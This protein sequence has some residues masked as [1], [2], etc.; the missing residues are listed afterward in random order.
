[1]LRSSIPTLA[2]FL[3]AVGCGNEAP[4]PTSD[5]ARASSQAKSAAPTA[6]AAPSAA[7]APS[8]TATADAPAPSSASAA[9]SSS[10]APSAPLFP[11][12]KPAPGAPS[13]A[14]FAAAPEI[15]VK[16]SSEQKCSTKVLQGWFEMVCGEAEGLVRARKVD[17]E[18]GF[19][20]ASVVFEPDVEGG[21]TMRFVA[22][23]PTSGELSR[24][25]FWG[26]DLHEIF[27]TLENT[28]KGW[29]GQLTGKRP[30]P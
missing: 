25:R 11:S 10:A 15:A 14:D 16:A 22:A 19:E 5:S 21:K 7:P 20:K 23:L 24:A 30:S 3:F 4:A 8:S 6:S 13:E 1:M 17:I 26:K 27:L 28:D 12:E 2:L 29:K 18:S 9:P